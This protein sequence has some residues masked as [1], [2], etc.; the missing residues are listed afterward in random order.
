MKISSPPR[1]ESR[2]A[3]AGGAPGEGGAAAESPAMVTRATQGG[4]RLLKEFTDYMS[5][6]SP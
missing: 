3:Q 2:L 5:N 1:A 4:E 6:H